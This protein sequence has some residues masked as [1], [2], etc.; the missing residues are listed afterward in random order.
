MQ[1]LQ[2]IY[3]IYIVFAQINN[4]MHAL[5]FCIKCVN[6]MRIFS[7]IL[8]MISR[9]LHKITLLIWIPKHTTCG[10]IFM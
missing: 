7:Y 3:Y 5:C 8:M 1:Q 10:I 6:G 9:Y 2:H 4:I